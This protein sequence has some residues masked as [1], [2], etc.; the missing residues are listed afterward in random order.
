MRGYNKFLF[1]NKWHIFSFFFKKRILQF[2]RPKWKKIQKRVCDSLKYYKIYKK[3]FGMLKFYRFLK[4]LKYLK[5]KFLFKKKIK[6]KYISFFKKLKFFILSRYFKKIKRNLKFKLNYP[7]KNLKFLYKKKKKFKHNFKNFFFSFHFFQISHFITRS[8]FI[9][10]NL[11]FMKSTVLKYYNGCLSVKHF[12]KIL[13]SSKYKHNLIFMFVKPE[14]RL[15]ILLWRLK[16]FISPYLA[17][18]AFQNSL[19]YINNNLIFKFN[20][21]KQHFT[22]FLKGNSLISLNSKLKYFYKKNSRHFLKSFFL[23]TFFEI[24][25]Y[26]GNII[27]L[28][29]LNSLTFKDVNSML[30][31]PLCLYKFKDY[32]FK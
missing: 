11:L 28:K 27:I 29:D 9:F 22:R 24:D 20:S 25:Y 23:S 10:K 30:K 16:F 32:I 8:R 21:F 17:R 7:F 1:K 12:K 15:D 6:K 4:N 19:I 18:F 13:F 5:K 3:K 31:E 26:V 2:K 14:F